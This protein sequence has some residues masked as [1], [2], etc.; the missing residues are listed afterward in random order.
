M[1]SDLG[2]RAKA[3]GRRARLTPDL[4]VRESLRLL[5]QD[6][7]AGFSLPKLGVALGADPTA[8]Y[9]HFSSK[10]DLMIAARETAA[11]VRTLRRQGVKVEVIGEVVSDLNGHLFSRLF[12]MVAPAEIRTSG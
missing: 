8:V 5:D 11:Q 3:T 4:I 1:A 7:V 6:G 10:D 12:E 2:A 9:R